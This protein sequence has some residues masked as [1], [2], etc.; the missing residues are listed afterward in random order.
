[1][2]GHLTFTQIFLDVI[3]TSCPDLEISCFKEWGEVDE[4]R[5]LVEVF[6]FI[7]PLVI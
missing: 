4:I 1:M 2:L 7:Y 6:S 5:T 3:T